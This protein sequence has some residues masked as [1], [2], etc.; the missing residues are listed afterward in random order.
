[1]STKSIFITISKIFTS[2][3]QLLRFYN[4][5]S[6]RKIPEGQKVKLNLKID[7]QISLSSKKKKRTNKIN[8][9]VIYMTE[10]TAFFIIPVNPSLKNDSFSKKNK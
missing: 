6:D 4:N 5:N 10:S 2:Q 9:R 8:A 3:S 7:A 1:M